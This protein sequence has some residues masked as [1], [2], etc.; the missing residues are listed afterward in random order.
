MSA[1]GKALL[2][3]GDGLGD[4]P[5]PELAGLTPVEA[6]KT[7]NLDRLAAAGECG[8][9]DPIAPGIP[10]GSDTAHLAY[11]GYDPHTHYPGRGPFEAMGI[12][13]EVRPGDIAF[14]CNFATIDGNGVISDRRAGRIR[15]GTAD[16][17][18][19]LNGLTVDGVQCFVRE[20]VEHRAA[21]VLRGGKLGDRVIDADPDADGQ[22]LLQATGEDADSQRTAAAINAFVARS[23]EVLADHPVNRARAACGE[24]VANIVLPRGAGRAPNLA[25]FRE[26]S[27]LTG[28]LVVE[29]GLVKG[30][31][32][33]IGM[34]VVDVPGAL[35][36]LQTDEI[37]LAKAAVAA[38][39]GHDFVLCNLKC[40]D[41][42]GHDGDPEAKVAACEKL[43]RMAA[44]ILESAAARSDRLY[45]A[46]TGD[47]TT[48]CATRDHTGEPVPV[49][50]WGPDVRADQVTAFGER[51]CAIGGLGRLRGLDLL[52]VLT[53]YIGAA[54]K[55]GA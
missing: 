48:A 19:A 22:P 4:R 31:G 21:L 35:G 44:L 36:N 32:R 46:V 30:I 20:S 45:V 52:P 37:A 50:L 6:A 5:C 26:T 39:D 14:R 11:L 27:G 23:R 13:M 24:P 47:H 43:D 49:A 2:L 3:I 17:A 29:V 16:L 10:P 53:S 34:T 8:L 38:L 25:S 41:V 15:D 9:I 33:Y 54:K 40:P 28:A 7:P 1:R 51:T 18:A 55:F 42:A 12:G